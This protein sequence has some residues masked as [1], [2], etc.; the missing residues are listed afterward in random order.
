MTNFLNNGAVLPTGLLGSHAQDMMEG[1]NKSYKNFPLRVGV[2]TESYPVSDEGNRSKLTTEYDVLVVEQ[3]ADRGATTIQYRNCLSCEG[4]GSIADYFE[5]ALRKK[6]KKTTKGDSVNLKGQN[7]AIVLMLCLDGMSD[8]GIIISA[9]THPDRKTNLVDE[10]PFL[11]GEYNGVQIKVDTDGS[12]TFT[13]RGAT[14]NDGNLIDSTQ[15]P[16]V[17]QVEKDGSY[18]V[19]HKTIMQRFDKGGDAS[20][21][22]QGNISNTASKDFNVTATGGINLTATKDLTAAMA[23]C[24]I[25]ASGSASLACQDLTVNAQSSISFKGSELKVEA[26]GMANIKA[27]QI[28]LDGITNLGGPGGQPVLLLTSMMLGIGNLGIPVISNVISGYAVK[29]FAK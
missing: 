18:Q 7:G 14:D 6:K 22:A 19:S 17:V 1:F 23:K 2:V 15:G 21:T 10:G 8:K 28:T 13:F 9:L 24:V 16:T 27:P 29:T 25:N 11:M 12:A 20:L 26:Q 3:N 4:L 5:K